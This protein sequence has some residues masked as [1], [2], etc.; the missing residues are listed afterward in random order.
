MSRV[1]VVAALIRTLFGLGVIVATII[2]EPLLAAPTDWVISVTSR[3][4]A[5]RGQ[6]VEKSVKEQLRGRGSYSNSDGFFKRKC[7]DEQD[8][9]ELGSCIVA[10]Y[11]CA[12]S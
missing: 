4:E 2:I 11:K 5:V 7:E 9:Y 10:T 3:S 12:D 1:P 8:R 6:L